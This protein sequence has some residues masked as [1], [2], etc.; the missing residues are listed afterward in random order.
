MNGKWRTGRGVREGGGRGQRLLFPSMFLLQ[1]CNEGRMNEELTWT[2]LGVFL[3]HGRRRKDRG[4]GA[5]D[6]R[7]P[8]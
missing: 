8:D 5:G 1:L 3:F 4:R 6:G 2:E 7:E